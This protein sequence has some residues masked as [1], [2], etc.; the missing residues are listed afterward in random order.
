ML[1]GFAVS[2]PP[3]KSN[4]DYYSALQTKQSDVIIQKALQYPRNVN[5][6]VQTAALLK[7]NDFGDE[8]LKLILKATVE[9]PNTFE[10][11]QVLFSLENA[12]VAQKSVALSQMKRLDP[13][14]PD[15]K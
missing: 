12:S 11:W 5:I 15:L 9:S 14:N 1:F 13:H 10:A 8:S 2:F 4:L 7:D 6:M 3:V